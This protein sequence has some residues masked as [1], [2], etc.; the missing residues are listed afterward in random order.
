MKHAVWAGAINSGDCV[1][2]MNAVAQVRGPL[3]NLVRD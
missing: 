3:C 1:G 2:G